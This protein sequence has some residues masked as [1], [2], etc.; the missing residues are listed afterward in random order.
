M[1]VRVAGGDGD[2]DPGPDLRAY[3]LALMGREAV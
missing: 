1:A 2:P 3:D